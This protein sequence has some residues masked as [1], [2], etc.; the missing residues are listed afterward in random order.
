M[1]AILIIVLVVI[2][3]FLLNEYYYRIA[4]DYTQDFHMRKGEK[5]GPYDAIS[6]G[7]AYC[8]FGL[9]FSDCEIRGYNFGY[10]SQFFYYTNLMLHQYAKT[11]K[12]G[13]VVY[14]IIADLV[15][16]KVGKGIY[17]SDEYI[18]FLDKDLLGDEYSSKAYIKSR[19]PVLFNPRLVTRCV[20]KMLRMTKP[21]E[22]ETLES[23][24]LSE[25]QVEEEADKRCKSWCRQFD[26]SDTVG[27]NTHKELEDTFVETRRILTSM[28]QFCL[29]SGL[30][31][32]LVVT[33]VSKNMNVRLSD[34]F[35]NRM[36][37]DN[38]R[39]ANKQHVPL[40]NYLRDERFSD[41]TLYY[42]NADF[43]NAR[44]R[45]LFT[46]VLVSD[47]KKIIDNENRNTDIS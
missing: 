7:S 29:D 12:K 39:I 44:G 1:I 9:D 13:G 25:K 26:L 14:L 28:I 34:A 11:C 18:K 20:K 47:T 2:F 17:G 45:K 30:K 8:R 22:F 35:I 46:E 33:P 5:G 23:N 42:N 27:G 41:Y 43:L 24:R 4:G 6:F 3:A 37:F 36:L 32:V 19:F 21:T 38:I 40:M 16:A 31:P 10:G 15:F